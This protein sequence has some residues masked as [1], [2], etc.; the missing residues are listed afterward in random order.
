MVAVGRTVEHL[1]QTAGVHRI[2]EGSR[3]LGA[4][5]AMID[6][7][8]GIALNIN[9]F[10]VFD[11]DVEAAT[12]CAVWADAV[13]KLRIANARSF[14]AAFDAERLYPGAYLHD[15][16]YGGLYHLRQ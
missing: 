13:K 14:V 1:R 16:C 5:L 9:H 7:T 15:L 12:H 6:G 3:S 2:L 8:I 10:A 11:V 4:E